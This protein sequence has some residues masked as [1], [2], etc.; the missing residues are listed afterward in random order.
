[1][2]E[3]VH[4]SHEEKALL[5]CGNASFALIKHGL[6]KPLVL[7]IIVLMFYIHNFP[8]NIQQIIHVILSECSQTFILVH[9]I[10]NVSLTLLP[11][12]IQSLVDFM[13]E[14]VI[15]IQS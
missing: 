2:E 13:H 14:I 4:Y 10:Q 5:K 3:F 8:L 1:M 7:V 12:I 11:A 9:V 15:Q 6:Y